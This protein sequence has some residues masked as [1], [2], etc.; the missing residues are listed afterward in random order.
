MADLVQ[1]DDLISLVRFSAWS[2]ARPHL[3]VAQLP[4][5]LR[6][7]LTL[8]VLAAGR[9]SADGRWPAVDWPLHPGPGSPRWA[10]RCFPD[11]GA[12]TCH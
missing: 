7:C 9:H 1:K 4:S 2:Q 3:L 12:A 8:S 6:L 5:F 11:S 10:E